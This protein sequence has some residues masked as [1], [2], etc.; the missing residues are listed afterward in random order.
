MGS[1]YGCGAYGGGPGHSD[2]GQTDEEMEEG[3]GEDQETAQASTS[4][5][6][7]P[8]GLWTVIIVA[9]FLVCVIAVFVCFFCG[10]AE[11]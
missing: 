3:D 2:P 10:K 9:L 5:S 11:R 7:E 8:A 1:T 6:E 4:K